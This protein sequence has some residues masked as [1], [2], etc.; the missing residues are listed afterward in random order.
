MRGMFLFQRDLRIEDQAG[1]AAAIGSCDK[2]LLTAVFDPELQKLSPEPPFCHNALERLTALLTLESQLKEKN[3][4]IA[5]HVGAMIPWILELSKVYAIEKVWLN[6]VNE[7]AYVKAYDA[8]EKALE[9]Q[10]IDLIRCFD[11]YG[12]PVER[13][14]KDDGEVYKVFTPFYKRWRSLLS[15]EEL[16]LFIIPWRNINICVEVNT[17]NPLLTEEKLGKWQEIK[18]EILKIRKGVPLPKEGHY[19]E[20]WHR[21]LSEKIKAYDNNRDYP[22]LE[23]TSQLSGA[24]NNGLIS[25]RQL[26]REAYLHPEGEAFLRQLAW[27]QF[28]QMILMNFPNVEKEAFREVY[29]HLDW[30]NDP[31]LFQKWKEGKTGFPIVDAAMRQLKAEGK[32]HNRLRMV[33]AS[34]LVKHLAVDWRLG[35]AYFY[36]MLRDGDLALNN[37]GW[38]WCASTGTDAQPYFRIFNPIRQAERY[39]PDHIYRDQWVKEALRPCVDLKAMSSWTIQHYKNAREGVFTNENV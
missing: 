26:V 11:D 35:E 10:D 28:Y 36:Q 14:H 30:P 13:L 37:G 3:M 7:P 20:I 9:I 38:Q 34:F 16:S 8:L 23:A 12:V 24:I 15:L 33:C 5:I 1:L 32:M 21:F 6:Q 39:D 4:P 27:R 25:Y 17:I 18:S 31:V 22:S 19:Q 29:R 2:I